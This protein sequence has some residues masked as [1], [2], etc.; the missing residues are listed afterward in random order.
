METK[1][2]YKSLGVWG[3]IGAILIFVIILIR[4]A[5][6]SSSVDELLKNLDTLFIGL[7]GVVTSVL[8]LYGRLKAT[9]EIK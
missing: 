5:W 6:L 2:W 7:S 9:K 1:D 4:V 3:C 8:G